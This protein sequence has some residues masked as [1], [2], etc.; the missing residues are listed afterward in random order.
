MRS[1]P[2][3]DWSSEASAIAI[4]GSRLFAWQSQSPSWKPPFIRGW[5]GRTYYPG[6]TLLQLKCDYKDREGCV[7]DTLSSGKYLG[8][9]STAKYVPLSVFH[10]KTTGATVLVIQTICLN[11][12]SVYKECREEH[13]IHIKR[14]TC[15]LLSRVILGHIIQSIIQGIGERSFSKTLTDKSQRGFF[16][17]QNL[18]SRF[19]RVSLPL[20]PFR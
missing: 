19:N 1:K 10:S 12:H 13:R 14:Q 8:P 4:Q 6:V 9:K 17:I 7:W 3:G 18:I 2:Q 16:F 11:S 5:S 20:C 15:G